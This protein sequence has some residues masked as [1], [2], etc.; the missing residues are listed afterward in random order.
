MA[1]LKPPGTRRLM[2][3]P[4]VRAAPEIVRCWLRSILRH[5]EKAGRRIEVREEAPVRERMPT[6]DT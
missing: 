4:P 3:S 5:G 6:I 2:E 1:P